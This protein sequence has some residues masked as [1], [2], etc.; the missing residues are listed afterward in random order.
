[1]ATSIS[2]TTRLIR[3][4]R[5]VGANREA[6]KAP[7]D[8]KEKARI[9][10]RRL[11]QASGAV[12]SPGSRS[13]PRNISIHSWHPWM[14]PKAAS[15]VNPWA[16]G[17]SDRPLAKPSFATKARWGIRRRARWM[18]GNGFRSS[19]LPLPP[20]QPY[21]QRTNCARI[22]AANLRRRAPPQQESQS[23]FRAEVVLTDAR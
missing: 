8:K 12:N 7:R 15:R 4:R 21:P 2:G 19:R 9:A 10:N 22:K 18:I 20:A 17:S 11:S 14:M 23:P 6:P 1:M 3:R 13:K 16:M 5:T